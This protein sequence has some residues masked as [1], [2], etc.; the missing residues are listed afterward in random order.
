MK[1]KLLIFMML[2]FLCCFIIFDN[3]YI[4][5]T[6]MTYISSIGINYNEESNKVEIYAYIFN[7]FSL[8]KSEYNT[9]SSTEQAKSIYS[10]ADNTK[11]AFFNLANT[12]HTSIDYSHIESLIIHTSY[13]QE[14]FLKELIDFLSNHP[15][16]YAKFYVYVTNNTIKDIYNI[17]YFNDTSSYYT[18]ITDHK[19]DI[20]YHFTPF[21][22][23]VNDILIKDY[24]CLYPA[25][26]C[27]PNIINSNEE[28]GNSLFIDGYYYL[29]NNEI[30]RLYFK[31]YNMLYL[32]YSIN[33]VNFKMNDITYTV[34]NYDAVP[35]K[36]LKKLYFLYYIK[37]DYPKSIERELYNFISSMYDQNID[38]Y[39]LKYYGIDINDLIIIKAEKNIS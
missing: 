19:S 38:F 8:S 36:F 17:D 16:F 22:E 29:E 20:I 13:F 12:S 34:F 9:G 2:F 14:N 24:F 26:N 27:N 33:N 11:D 39:N 15:K 23:L 4:D 28:N 18:I 32:I 1:N 37:T 5:I 10:E 3:D 25:L 35:V 30:K 21:L 31:D 6:H 7:N